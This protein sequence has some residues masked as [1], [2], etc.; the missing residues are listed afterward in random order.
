M[1][2]DAGF[3]VLAG[4]CGICCV[5][6]EASLFSWCTTKAY[7]AGS[8]TTQSG[9][10]GRCC[11]DSFNE[12]AFDKAV[13]KDLERTRSPGTTGEQPASQTTMSLVIPGGDELAAGRKSPA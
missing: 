11:G 4:C 13:Q 10:C 8:S 3:S 12:D 7:G 2:A 1:S 9:C 5:C 6:C